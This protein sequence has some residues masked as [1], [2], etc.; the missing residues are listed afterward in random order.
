MQVAAGLA[1][2]LPVMLLPLTGGSEGSGFPTWVRGSLNRSQ[3][4]GSQSTLEDRRGEH[5][6]G[7]WP[8]T[9]CVL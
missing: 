7:G 3:T 1:G 5:G 9:P 6:V 8:P 4:S 2:W